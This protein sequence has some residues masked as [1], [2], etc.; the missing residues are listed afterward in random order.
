[1]SPFSRKIWVLFGVHEERIEW[2][3][4]LIRWLTAIMM[5]DNWMSKISS[6]RSYCHREVTS[7]QFF[8][9]RSHLQ[10]Q[11]T[12]YPF[13]QMPKRQIPTKRRVHQCFYPVEPPTDHTLSD[14]PMP[15]ATPLCLS[16]LPIPLPRP[17]LTSEPL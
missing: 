10:P 7:M 2:S 17:R 15:P 16:R 13:A 4:G 1:M 3:R 6:V 9:V 11:K 5:T 12:Q 14:V 8:N